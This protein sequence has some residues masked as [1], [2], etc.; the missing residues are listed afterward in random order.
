M[1]TAV[2]LL[3]FVCHEFLIF[4]TCYGYVLWNIMSVY[5]V[6]DKVGIYNGQI[7]HISYMYKY[8]GSCP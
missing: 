5:N 3:F 6:V 2:V 7:D 1:Y 4:V 8:T